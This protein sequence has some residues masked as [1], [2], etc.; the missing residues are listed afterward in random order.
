MT[1]ATPMNSG[2]T[3]ALQA[4]FVR[5]IQDPEAFWAEAAAAIHWYKKWDKVLD[6]S[7]AP[8][9]RWFSGGELNTCYNALDLHVETGRADQAVLIY[10]SPVTNQI[11][12][13]TYRELRD[14]V[15]RFAGVLAQ[16]SVVKGCFG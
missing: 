7:R 11:K 13:F 8:F 15:A 1:I 16:Q 9:Y 2:T 3:G 5:S 12:I 6:N 10:D 14:A 4:A